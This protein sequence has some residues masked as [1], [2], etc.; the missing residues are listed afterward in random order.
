M[1]TTLERQS[2]D[3]RFDWYMSHARALDLGRRKVCQIAV[4]SHV[5]L[6]TLERQSRDMRFDWYMSHARALDLG[7]R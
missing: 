6:T 5:V 2:R 7:R 1:L 4:G 3:M